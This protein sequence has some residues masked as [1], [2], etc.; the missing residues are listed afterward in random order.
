M[1]NMALRTLEL[2]QADPSQLLEFH[3]QGTDNSITLY[4]HVYEKAISTTHQFG[5]VTFIPKQDK[6]PTEISDLEPPALFTC[7]H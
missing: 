2:Q 5:M 6:H 7:L 4:L 3:Q 1:V